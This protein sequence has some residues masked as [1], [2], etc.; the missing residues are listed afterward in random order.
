MNAA[1]KTLS[2]ICTMPA[3]NITG[4]VRTKINQQD[5]SYAFPD[6]SRLVIYTTTRRGVA[7][8]GAV[9]RAERGIRVNA[10]GA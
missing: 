6:G 9:S 4:A 7:A 8:K 1:E 3:F 5:T 10:V 2:R